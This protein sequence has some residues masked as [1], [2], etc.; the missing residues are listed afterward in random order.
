[1][2]KRQKIFVLLLFFLVLSLTSIMLYLYQKQN[3][4]T[5]L[6]QFMEE[7]QISQEVDFPNLQRDGVKLYT[8]DG[9]GQKSLALIQGKIIG[10]D[11]VNK[12]LKIGFENDSVYLSES[13][14]SD[15]ILLKGDQ[16]PPGTSVSIEDDRIKIGDDASFNPPRHSG[17][18]SILIIHEY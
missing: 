13:E 15:I 10:I 17:A 12:G 11:K 6:D 16:L 2:S 5:T 18:K 7:Y 4:T 1:M 14:V 8:I 9:L 3:T